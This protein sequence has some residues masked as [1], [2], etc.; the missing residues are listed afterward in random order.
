ME[1]GQLVKVYDG[2]LVGF[3]TATLEELIAVVEEGELERW[4]MITEDGTK[5]CRFIK[6]YPNPVKDGCGYIL[7]EG[8]D[9]FEKS[10]YC[11]GTGENHYDISKEYYI[12]T[13]E[14][15]EYIDICYCE[16]PEIEGVTID[17]KDILKIAEII[18]MQDRDN[19]K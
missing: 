10:F 18:K 8:K 15:S 14:D 5:L 16:T 1:K 6:N 7:E 3:V 19:N 9:K 11:K 12:N 2:D 13:F 4:T 17:R